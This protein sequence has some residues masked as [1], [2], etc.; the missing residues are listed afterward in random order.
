MIN[1]ISNILQAIGP[2]CMAIAITARGPKGIFTLIT[3][4]GCISVLFSLV[5]SPK[6]I[7]KVDDKLRAAAGKKLDDALADKL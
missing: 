6:R 2:A 4:A 5:F 1:P 7:R 3:I